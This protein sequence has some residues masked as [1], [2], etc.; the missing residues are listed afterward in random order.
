MFFI[1]GLA[2]LDK[3][4]AVADQLLI[5]E[6]INDDLNKSSDDEIRFVTPSPIDINHMINYATV[7]NTSHNTQTWDNA[8]N[9]YFKDTNRFKFSN[10][11]PHV[12]LYSN[13]F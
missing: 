8:I 13:V 2:N 12:I 9:K 4:I 10:N 1:V 3:A 5:S 7:K 6:D 11:L